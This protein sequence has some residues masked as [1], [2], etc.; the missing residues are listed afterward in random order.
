MMET[1]VTAPRRPRW[2]GLLAGLLVLLPACGS[3]TT[4]TPTPTPPAATA[5]TAP[6]NA[7]EIATPT[8][9]TAAFTPTPADTPTSIVLPTVMSTEPPTRTPIPVAILTAAPTAALATDT[10]PPAT[11]PPQAAARPTATDEPEECFRS[12]G[13]AYS[14]YDLVKAHK[15][16]DVKQI[17]A[18]LTSA[19]AE[20]RWFALWALGSVHDPAGLPPLDHYLTTHPK[21]DWYGDAFDLRPLALVTRAYIQAPRLPGKTN[22]VRYIAL[23]KAIPVFGP[24]G[25]TAAEPVRRVEP[26]MALTLVERV[27]TEATRP[28]H[29]GDTPLVFEKVQVAGDPQTYY[30]DISGYVA[31]TP[32]YF[33]LPEQVEP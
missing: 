8:A 13:T 30:M 12:I 25:Q 28:D 7:V 2:T 20:D 19:C 24:D 1:R 22:A 27:P 14:W 6:T 15:V 29:G 9:T 10:P 17:A 23:Y 11:R 31:A 4:D 16:G 3:G 26:G 18:G 21:E 5:T 33:Q 32:Q